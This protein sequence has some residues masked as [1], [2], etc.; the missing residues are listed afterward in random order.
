MYLRIAKN[1]TLSLKTSQIHFFTMKIQ[2]ITLL[3]LLLSIASAVDV[4][5]GKL[6]RR[7][8]LKWGRKSSSKGSKGRCDPRVAIISDPTK[9]GVCD[10]VTACGTV[11]FSC[12]D[13]ESDFTLV[14]YEL[15]GLTDGLHALHVHEKPV[16][17]DCASTGG[18]WNPKN[19]NHGSNLSFQRHI[20]DLGNVEV[21]DGVASGALLA[22]V[23]I[24][25]DLGIE[26]LAVVVHAGTDDLG[27]GG[28]DGSR[29]V[30][31]AGARPGCGTIVGF[32]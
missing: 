5:N 11:T 30:G 29:A 3:P 13:F 18:H 17:P 9:P 21:V 12:P 8:D 28:N 26:G 25:G 20:G 6:V 15:S 2:A 16:M 31:N 10:S 32:E 7:R 23:P 22:N 1:T 19:N 24:S 27:E 4:Q 14:S